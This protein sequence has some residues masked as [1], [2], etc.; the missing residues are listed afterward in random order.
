MVQQATMEVR[1]H[2]LRLSPLWYTLHFLSN[3]HFRLMIACPS[4]PDVTHAS[5]FTTHLTACCML[6]A[7]HD[8]H[9]V[10]VSSQALLNGRLCADS[11]VIDGS[12]NDRGNDP[13]PLF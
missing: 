3:A 6:K 8:M 5:L 12:V 7:A 11:A 2:F 10:Q 1:I 9:N 13:L 4:Q